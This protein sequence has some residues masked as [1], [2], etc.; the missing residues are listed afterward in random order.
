MLE[1]LRDLPGA[2]EEPSYFDDGC[3]TYQLT[4]QPNQQAQVSL[5]TGARGFG[6]SSAK[7]WMM[8]VSV[9]SLV[10]MVPE[11]LADLSDATGGNVSRDLLDSD[12]VRRIWSSVRDLRDVHGVA[13]EA[14]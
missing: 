3:P 11:P 14:M 9:E 1:K 2:A 8:S 10:A 13:E 12:F 7:A 6:L 4:L 5:S